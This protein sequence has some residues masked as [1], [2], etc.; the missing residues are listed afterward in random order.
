MVLE[1]SSEWQNWLIDPYAVIGV[2]VT[3][4]GQRLVKRYRSVAK[5]LHP[6][7]YVQADPA[8]R[9]LVTQLLTRLVN[10]AYGKVKDD[11]SQK[12]I[13][14][15]IKLQAQQAAK[16]RV[17]LQTAIARSLKSQPTG[18]VDS[19]YEQQVSALSDRQYTDLN[20]FS[21]VTRSLMELNAVYFQLKHGEPT[22]RPRRTGLM[23]TPSMS[24]AAASSA[25]AS[26]Q[27]SATPT[28]SPA[29]TS[30]HL[31]ARRH[32]DRAKHYAQT[33]GWKEAIT[34]LKDAIRMDQSCSDYHALLG[35]VYFKQE[36]RGMA[37]VHFKQALK[38]NPEDKLAKR[39]L[40]YVTDDRSTAIPDAKTPEKRKL[41]G[42]FGR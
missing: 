42:I 24:Q 29:Q 36:Q 28:V 19:F 30:N 39:F 9:Q 25:Q 4:D 32:Y 15:L 5:L 22:W 10:P 40:P 2:P 31:Y 38:L 18:Y 11:V 20:A 3:A 12:E 17:E 14:V 1:Y 26:A 16:D 23:S 37:R 21:E 6:D 33:S 27:H 41:F 8:V 35:F 34:E 13:L 7:R